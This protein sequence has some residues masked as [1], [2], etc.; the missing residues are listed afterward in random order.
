MQIGGLAVG[1]TDSVKIVLHN[2]T[3]FDSTNYFTFTVLTG[4]SPGSLVTLSTNPRILVHGT[5]IPIGQAQAN[6]ANGV[7]LLLGKY[8]TVE[9]VVTVTNQF[10]G[11]GYIQ[12]NS[13]GIAIYDSS[14]TNHVNIGDKIIVLGTMT[15]FNGLAELDPATLIQT[16]STGNTVTPLVVTCSQ[17]ANDGVGGNENYEGLL[18]QINSVSLSP[19]IATWAVSGSGTNYNMTDGTGTVQIRVVPSVNYANQSAP[20]GPFSVIC[21]VGQFKSASPYIG[22]YQVQPRFLSDILT[23]GPVITTAPVREQYHFL[24]IHSQLDRR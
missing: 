13:D 7:N 5:P 16:V 19:P 9:G 15:Q 1:G 23:S 3:P 14:L 2:V 20:Q 18:V 8:V 17:I 6:D 12:D 4:V 11:A 10:N 21:V 24:I 22:G